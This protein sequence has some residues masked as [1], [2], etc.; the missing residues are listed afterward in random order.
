MEMVAVSKV[1]LIVLVMMTFIILVNY[2]K[3]TMA[4][5]PYT[6]RRKLCIIMHQVSKEGLTHYEYVRSYLF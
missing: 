5:L 3:N 6:I 4:Y 2:S 1:L